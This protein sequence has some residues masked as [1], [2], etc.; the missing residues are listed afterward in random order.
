MICKSYEVRFALAANY[1]LALCTERIG[2]LAGMM[3][4][5]W[6]WLFAML[7]TQYLCT[8]LFSSEFIILLQPYGMGRVLKWVWL[9]GKILLRTCITVLGNLLEGKMLWLTFWA[10]CRVVAVAGWLKSITLAS[11]CLTGGAA[12]GRKAPG[13]MARLAYKHTMIDWFKLNMHVTWKS[14]DPQTAPLDTQIFKHWNSTMFLFWF[15]TISILY[16]HTN[17]KLFSE[18]GN[19]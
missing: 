3:H 14:C 9:S 13:L 8:A 6:T 16:L 4:C 10:V 1:V 12:P 18:I 2:C 15:E 17:V 7:F 19:M 5:L 11:G